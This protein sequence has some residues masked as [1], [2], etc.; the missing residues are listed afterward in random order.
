MMALLQYLCSFS[1]L[2]IELQRDY[3]TFPWLRLEIQSWN[4]FLSLS[5]CVWTLSLIPPCWCS[6]SLTSRASLVLKSFFPVSCLAFASPGHNWASQVGINE[7]KTSLSTLFENFMLSQK[8][9]LCAWHPVCLFF[10]EQKHLFSFYAKWKD[11][12]EHQFKLE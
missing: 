2:F 6:S 12:Y 4:M 10:Q 8:H 1:P 5:S 7:E 11:H 3:V 9:R